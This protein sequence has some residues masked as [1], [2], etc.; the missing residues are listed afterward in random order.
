MFLS[1]AATSFDI[2]SLILATVVVS[3][4]GLLIGLFLG[5][6]SKKL[7]VPVDEK[8]AK[9]R[10]LLPGANC[11]GCGYAGCDACAK[12][13]ANQEAA[14]DV[15]PVA[16]SDIHVEIAKL[17]GSSVDTTEKQVAYVKC[18]GTCDK[19]KKNSNYYGPKDCKLA[20]GIG[21]NG[22]KGCSYGCMGFGSCVKV[23]AFD[24]IHIVDGIALVDKEKCTACGIC[25][26]E[27]PINIIEMLP[28]KAKTLVA[29]SSLDKGKDVKPVCSTGCI[30]CKLCTKACQFDAIHVENN[31]AKI[32]YS[33]CT[34]CG[35]CVK[36]CPVKVIQQQSA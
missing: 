2:K 5:L 30:G 28:T 18:A 20:A 8:E 14:A 35:A 34:N 24:A 1:I 3:V 31:L 21:G 36:V 17:M 16:S 11:G 13:I 23:C 6:A 33:K 10:E 27:C 9:V 32:D 19:A 25:V 29:C 26:A 4:I 15:C 22:S 7:E 12:A